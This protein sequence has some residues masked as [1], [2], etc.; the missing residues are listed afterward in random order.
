MLW[1][2]GKSAS[3]WWP[4]RALTESFRTSSSSKDDSSTLLIFRWEIVRSLSMCFVQLHHEFLHEGTVCPMSNSKD[5]HSPSQWLDSIFRVTKQP[6]TQITLVQC[7]WTS[8]N[9]S[10]YSSLSSTSVAPLKIF[11]KKVWGASLFFVHGHGVQH[12]N[13][14]QQ[15]VLTIS[16][17]RQ[18]QSIQFLVSST[19]KAKRFHESLHSTGSEVRQPENFKKKWEACANLNR[20]HF[21]CQIT[22]SVSYIIELSNWYS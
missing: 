11:L 17:I 13:N 1:D 18:T 21:L 22:I 2:Q 8:D 5:I 7:I 6:V 19:K 10:N 15:D 3:Q 9:N 16:W 4:N 20:P 12:L 14:A